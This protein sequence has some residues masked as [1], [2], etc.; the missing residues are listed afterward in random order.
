MTIVPEPTRDVKRI[1]IYI[2]IYIGH[3]FSTRALTQ[4]QAT[5]PL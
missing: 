4:A 5:K 3:Q 1:G 2:Y